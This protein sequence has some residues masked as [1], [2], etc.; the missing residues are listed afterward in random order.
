MQGCIRRV[1]LPA[2]LLPGDAAVPLPRSA[3]GGLAHSRGRLGHARKDRAPPSPA[4]PIVHK[5]FRFHML[6]LCN[7]D[8]I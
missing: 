2:H 5:S 6:Q 1:V 3:T 4:Q 8:D 7:T